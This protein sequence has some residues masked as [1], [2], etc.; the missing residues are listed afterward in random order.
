M[1]LTHRQ[2]PTHTHTFIFDINGIHVHKMG[3]KI[4]HFHTPGFMDSISSISITITETTTTANGER[5]RK[6]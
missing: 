2:R 4:I 1:L 3:K 5:E 6:W